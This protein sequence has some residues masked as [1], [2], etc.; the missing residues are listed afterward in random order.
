MNMMISTSTPGAATS[1]LAPSALAGA[2]PAASAPGASAPV[3]AFADWMG[4]DLSGAPQE[5][6]APADSLPAELLTG[7]DGAPADTQAGRDGFADDGLAA[8]EQAQPLAEELAALA[9]MMPAMPIP[10]QMPMQM[11]MP[12][13]AAAAAPAPAR[14][15]AAAPGMS[16]PAAAAP[17]PALPGASAP[18]PA[19]L[20]GAPM[21]AAPFQIAAAPAAPVAAAAPAPTAA[22][23]A[24]AQSATDAPAPVAA[25]AIA[26]SQ[27]AA[28][29]SSELKLA[30]ATPA[31]WQQPLREALGE[32]LQLQLSR[33]IDQAVIR[34]DP[35]NLGRI[36]I[37]IRHMGGNL[38]VNISATHSEVVRQLNTI[39]ETMRSD[40]AARQF[41]EVAVNVTSATRHAAGS[42]QAF[43]QQGRQRQ[44][45]GAPDDADPG[46]A[47]AEAGH[48]PSTFSLNGRES[49]V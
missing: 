33:N 41:T 2:A 30:A 38:E 40:L 31:A 11:P 1:A 26:P 34:L 47:L 44:Q 49:T 5:A 14:G 35:P 25:N 42:Q 37:A 24:D 9:A 17:L 7:A 43:D 27:P 18:A 4:L 6:A 10:M 48:P 15:D 3:T 22:I 20:G 32:R 45:D 13:M 16:A 28:P 8:Q 19:A 21:P 46:R 29:V 39:S 23:G 12:M 36:E